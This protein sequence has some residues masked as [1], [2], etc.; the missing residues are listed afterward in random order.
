MPLRWW[1]LLVLIAVACGRDASDLGEPVSDGAVAP[2]TRVDS[3]FNT[4]IKPSGP[5]CAVGVYRNGNVV[6]T[7]GYGVANVSS[8]APITA[9]TTFNLGSASKAFTALAVLMLEQEGKLSLD[10]DV[11]KWLPELPEY[12][13][14]IRLRD[15]L[16]HTSGLRDY[17]SLHELG[18]SVSTMEQF[19]SLMAAQRALNFPTGTKHGYSHSDY[20]VL[21]QVVERVTSAPLGDFIER[22]VL[23]PMGMR[24]S[25]VDDTRGRTSRDRAFGHEQTTNGHRVIFPDGSIVGGTNL[26]ASVADLAHWISNFDERRVGGDAITRMVS[27]PVLPS[28]DTIPYAYGVRHSTYR[29]LR[30]IARGGHDAGMTTEWIRFPEQDFSVATLCNSEE[31]LAGQ[32]AK[33]VADIFL[34]KQMQ[35]KPVRP[36]VPASASVRPEMLSR[37]AGM[38]RVPGQ[39]WM[40]QPIALRDGALGE[41]LFHD[42]RDDTLIVL[43]P[44]GGNQ[45]YEIGTTGNVGLFTFDTTTSGQ[46]SRLNISWNG[47]HAGTLERVPDNERWT[48]SAS[49]LA[50]YAGTWFSSDLDTGWQIA[51]RDGKLVI[52]RPASAALSLWPATPDVFF[53]GFGSWISPTYVNIQFHRNASRRITHMTVSTQDGDDAAMHIR[54]DRVVPP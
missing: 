18:R 26:Y 28:G 39:P 1:P 48:P 9:S 23:V 2:E 21:G 31:L 6:L 10:D 52:V 4:L 12:G 29:G 16:F 25:F 3:L 53:R 51:V 38:Y 43:N 11:R 24:A 5:G 54:F 37:F 32:L 50:E 34:E 7:R 45:F 19:H 49:A 41:V 27:R 14:P 8:G 15:L 36:L 20:V 22:E 40:I 13:E 17:G 44:A 30:T 46:S 42:V 47:E 35:P 33:S